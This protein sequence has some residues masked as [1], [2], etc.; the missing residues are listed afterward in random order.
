M[1]NSRVKMSVKNGKL[2]LEA[3]N[4]SGP[5]CKQMLD[6]V[7]KDLNGVVVSEEP[8]PELYEATSLKQQER[9]RQTE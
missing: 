2:Q 9:L 5:F 7:T 6:E 4:V 8:K 1:N 3:E